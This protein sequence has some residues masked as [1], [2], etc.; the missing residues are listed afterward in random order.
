MMQGRCLCQRIK[1]LAEMEILFAAS[2]GDY[3]V[4]LVTF[5]LVQEMGQTAPC[6]GKSFKMAADEITHH[7]LARFG[8]EP[9]Q[10]R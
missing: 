6:A 5:E 2:A 1:P 4:R 7:R 3:S 8:A 9:L 10:L